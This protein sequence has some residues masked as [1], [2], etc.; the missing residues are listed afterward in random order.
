VVF[1]FW[2]PCV[3]VDDVHVGGDVDVDVGHEDIGL[4]MA[5]SEDTW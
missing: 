5:R 1:T 2:S 4:D 3:H